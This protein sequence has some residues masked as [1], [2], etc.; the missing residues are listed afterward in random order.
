MTDEEKGKKYIEKS[1]EDCARIY[2][3]VEN[4]EE[5]ES[6]L[7]ILNV[8]GHMARRRLLYRYL[9]AIAVCLGVF[10]GLLMIGIGQ[11]AGNSSYAEAVLTFQY[12]G[13]E[14][15][16]DPN[17]AAF[18]INKLKSPAVIEAA[19]TDLGISGVEVETIRENIAI[20]G[21]IPEDAIE[22]ITVLQEMAEK[23]VSNY[24]K[25]LDVTYFPSQYVVSL[26]QSRG[27]SS[28]ETREILNAILESYKS[29][30][31]D[32]Y[33]NTAVLTVAGNLV[34]YQDYDYGESVDMIQ[35]QINMMQDYVTERRD[36]A[37][38]FRSADT[39]L[40][41]GD[42]VTALETIKSIDIANLASYI[43]NN[44]LT[45]DR[46]RQIE[47]YT[48]KIRDDTMTLAQ[49]QVQ[50][51][52]VQDTLDS[53]Q[54]DPVVIVSS[55]ESTQEIGQTNEYY[56]SLVQRKLE[57][58]EQIAETNTRL[59]DTY[60]KLDKINN[61]TEQ[62]TEAE[63]KK[64]DEMLD[65]ITATLSEW[66]GLIEETT[67]EYYTTTLFSNAVIIA[68]PAQY[69]AAGG[70]RA[71]AKRIL[72]CVTVLV[73]LVLIIWCIDGLRME[74]SVMRNRKKEG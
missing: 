54:K 8:A 64:A 2:L 39:G 35:S 36:Q 19:L 33:A 61:S 34:E 58:S 49:L 12:E 16:L 23:D 53:Y 37:P 74:L 52:T 15:G 45:K 43:D 47:Y 3:Q 5:K 68:V 7:D 73:M 30:F 44:T 10:A 38:D 13:I 65:R 70:I 27:M 46:Q 29:Y 11:M 50:L 26:Y 28:E 41:F 32:T 60:T 56:D 9:I 72:I 66:S 21:V 22:R 42:I 40:S 51:K 59:N 71:V 57:L 14:E 1:S 31:M 17:G 4:P 48:Y 25:I 69:K 55:Q 6:E 62:S 67:Q 63:Y 20:R 18:D 24:E